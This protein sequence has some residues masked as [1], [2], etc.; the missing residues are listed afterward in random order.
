MKLRIRHPFAVMAAETA[1]YPQQRISA[2]DKDGS[3][4]FEGTV[5]SLEEI[6]RWI[7][8]AAD[9][10][11][12]LEPEVL[13]EKVL[14]KARALLAAHEEPRCV[15]LQ[16]VPSSAVP[17]EDG[18]CWDE[19]GVLNLTQHTATEDQRAAGVRE[20]GR[21]EEVQRLLTFEALPSPE[22]VRRRA[23]DLAELA[24]DE[25][26]RRVMIGGA[27]FLMG[28]LEEAL[29]VRGLVPLYAFSERV[30]LDEMQLDGSVRRTLVFRHRGFVE[31]GRTFPPSPPG[32]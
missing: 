13:R 8:R 22:E 10:M 15:G 20:P 17:P 32:A 30:S 16:E 5:T 31:T 27:P 24:K 14:G 25:R 28:E 7:L 6:S 2:P 26:I 18:P 3:V 11:E 12:V 4:F 23:A 9:C 1:W 29:R 19:E 21:K